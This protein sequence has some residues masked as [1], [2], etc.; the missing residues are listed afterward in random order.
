VR[1]RL[2]GLQPA[3]EAETPQPG[4]PPWEPPLLRLEETLWRGD[5]AAARKLLMKFLELFRHE[6]LMYVPMSA[7][8]QPRAMLRAG[9]AQTILRALAANLPRVGLLRETLVVLQTAQAMEQN[10]PP[11]GLRV[12][13]FGRLC[14]LAVQAIVEAVLNS[15]AAAKN[16]EQFDLSRILERSVHPFMYLWHRHSQTF[17]VSVLETVRTEEEWAALR[18]FI[19]RYGRD[20]FHVRFLTPGNLRGILQRGVAAFLDDLKEHP[21]PLNPVN[22]VDD[23]DQAISRADAERHLQIIVQALLEN[24]EEFKDYSASAPQSDYG[25]NLYI[26]LDFLRLKAQYD[27]CAWQIKPL[28]LVHDVLARQH[29]ELA[30]RW[31]EHFADLAQPDA[32]KLPQQLAQL[33]KTHGIRLRTVADRI[34]ERFVKPLALDRLCALVPAALAAAGGPMADEVL[35]RLEKELAPHLAEPAGV[36]LDVP[37]WL[38]RLEATVQQTRASQTAIAEMAEELFRI[39]KV[40]VPLESLRDGLAESGG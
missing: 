9:I 37:P 2:L 31:Q 6:P 30:A 28:A 3:E 39:P 19:R 17:L 22:L 18:D 27:R 5:R 36:G 40:V 26:L 16:P 11:E 24:Y 21:D 25:D 4:R 35:A 38:A 23:L 7:G 8:G 34:G 13:D 1:G 14:Q 29:P 12:T 20:L 32:D 33:E 15:I 10:Q